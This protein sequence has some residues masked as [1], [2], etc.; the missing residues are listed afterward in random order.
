MGRPKKI[1]NNRTVYCLDEYLI[2]HIVKI[3]ATE[4]IIISLVPSGKLFFA[5]EAMMLVVSNHK[6]TFQKGTALLSLPF[7]S[8][9]NEP[10]FKNRT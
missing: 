9:Q 10:I 4:K 7:L 1:K 6:I 3:A 2:T 5:C 8:R